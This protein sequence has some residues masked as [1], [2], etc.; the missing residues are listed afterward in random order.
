[1]DEKQK[2]YLSIA[3]SSAKSLLTI[4]NDILDFSKIEAGRMQL[5]NAVFNLHKT[6]EDSVISMSK[7]A[8]ARQLDLN[9]YI[10]A[11]VQ[12]FV[13]GD[14]VRL[15][16]IITNLINNAIKF[17]ATG[18]VNFRLRKVSDNDR[19]V[20][21]C[22]EVED[23]GV[24]IEEEKLNSLFGAFTQADG[25]TTR[26]YGG[27]GLGLSIS[28]QLVS[29][30]GGEISVSSKPG[31][32]SIF[33]FI[34]VFPKVEQRVEP[35]RP[36]LP[37]DIRVL[38]VDD[39]DTNRTILGSYLSNWNIKN[40]GAGDAYAVLPMLRDASAEGKPYHVILLDF[41]LPKIGGL[42]LAQMIK[43]DG[44][45]QNIHVIM[46]S[47]SADL[48]YD[49]VEDMSCVDHYL[50][51]PTRQSDLFDVLLQVTG[52]AEKQAT[53]KDVHRETNVRFSGVRVL[54]V[55]D[56]ATNQAVGAEMLN[57]LGI[58][59][60]L[61]SDGRTALREIKKSDF[62]LVLMDCQMPMM[63]GYAATEI[64][65]AQEKVEGSEHLPIIALTANAMKGDREECISAGMD[66]YL[67]K[68]ITLD[69]LRR[70]LSQWLPDDLQHKAVLDSSE[71][72][73]VEEDVSAS[74]TG[75]V[76]LA[77]VSDSVLD[78]KILN[79]LRKLAGDRFASLIDS[80]ERDIKKNL[81]ALRDA[82]KQNDVEAV[83]IAA[84]TIKGAGMNMAAVRFSDCCKTLEMQ[85]R[86]NN[87]IDVQNQVKCIEDEYQRVIRELR[88]LS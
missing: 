11:N 53:G 23:T 69:S 17:T 29:M 74:K 71:G 48:D 16:Q 70:I 44:E 60:V 42:E 83:V 26:K 72:G 77:D 21:M 49:A 66:D 85:A 87:I 19:Q 47:S 50:A 84:H 35:K 63:D 55:D 24:G 38:V 8:E 1:L 76:N 39:N 15:R 27:T 88:K 57:E 58:E 65:R 52:R 22:F 54:L 12:T 18:E 67:A 30:M 37:E 7:Q 81:P 78:S 51:R 14:P 61:A 73:S 4:I 80:F 9:C 10:S 46:L 20:C 3:E 28:K 40:A 68:P 43:A 5:E 75:T 59:P 79:D 45:V 31:S 25:S 13:I 2:N 62:D 34:A 32:G 6:V 56:V 82:I 36:E 41:L 33:S 86:E 64:I